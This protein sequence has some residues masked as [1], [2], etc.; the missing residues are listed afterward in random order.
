MRS[1]EHWTKYLDQQEDELRKALDERYAEQESPT[2]ETVP[3]SDKRTT[4]VRPS[5]MQAAV[6]MRKKLPKSF[7][8]AGKREEVAQNSYQG[9]KETREELMER[10]LDPP[11]TLEEAARVLNVCPATVRRYTNRGSLKHFRTSGNQRRFRLSDVLAF[12][13]SQAVD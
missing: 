6:Q 5:E 4:E 10:L 11:L 3:A 8:A 1:L 13:K 2:E 12:M 7:R 9:F